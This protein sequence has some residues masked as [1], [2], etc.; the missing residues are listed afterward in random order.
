[1]ARLKKRKT[2]KKSKKTK[3]IV[4]DVDAI[5]CELLPIREFSWLS[6]ETDPTR[7]GRYHGSDFPDVEQFGS[8]RWVVGA[9]IMDE[10]ES[11][12]EEGKSD[13]EIVQGCIKF[14]NQPP[15]RRKFQKKI[16][17]PVYGNLNPAPVSYSFVQRGGVEVICALMVT[18][19][20]KN[21]K[22]WGEGLKL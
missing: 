13:D 22:F 2:S 7:L 6:S 18:D 3:P 15:P 17:K 20:R 11:L 1:M 16:R 14:L 19:K 8:K 5:D 9:Y 4:L 12:R 21:K 10:Y